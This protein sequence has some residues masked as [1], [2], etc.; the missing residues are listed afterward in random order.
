MIIGNKW[1]CSDIDIS[2]DGLIE[3]I[4]NNIRLMIWWIDI[5]QIKRLISWFSELTS[6][7][8]WSKYIDIS[9]M[10]DM[11]IDNKWSC[12]DIS[13]DKLSEIHISKMM[14]W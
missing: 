1:S 10:I 5:I 13:K 7:N 14:I 12:S 3:M 2:K 8:I 9:K 4:M 11:I 6:Y